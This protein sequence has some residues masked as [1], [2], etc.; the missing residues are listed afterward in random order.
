MQAL[1]REDAVARLW[2]G[3]YTLWGNDPTEITEPNRLGWLE[4][5]DSMQGDLD[6]LRAFAKDVAAAGYTTAVLMGMG[7]SSL[8]PEVLQA[9][10]GTT[11]GMLKV[12]VLDTTHHDSILDLTHAIDID[13]TLFIVSSKSGTTVETLSHFDYFWG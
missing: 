1:S 4:V 11:K 9:T 2:R 5:A 3:D 10:F 6:D 7:G 12:H 8:A 13:K